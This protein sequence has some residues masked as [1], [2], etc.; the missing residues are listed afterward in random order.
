MPKNMNFTL[1]E[2]LKQ[3]DDLVAK[4]NELENSNVNID[5]I[6]DDN[7]L[8]EEINSLKED[9]KDVVAEIKEEKKNI[10]EDIPSKNIEVIDNSDSVFETKIVNIINTVKQQKIIKKYTKEVELLVLNFTNYMNDLMDE[11]DKIN[12]I[13]SYDIREMNAEYNSLRTE[14]ESEFSNILNKLPEG[15]DFDKSLY[16]HIVKVFND[17][18]IDLEEFQAV[19]V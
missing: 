6:V 7:E 12:I 10:Q 18:E 14:F 15:V 13:T 1:E 3:K 19:D 2:L 9:I 8:K 11:Y 16:Q 4:L 5:E 17:I